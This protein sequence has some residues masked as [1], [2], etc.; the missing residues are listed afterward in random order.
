MS[1]RSLFFAGAATLAIS[2]ALLVLGAVVDSAAVM[3][4]GM[5][6]VVV[7]L[8][9][10]EWWSWREYGPR[11]RL[12]VGG[13]LLVVVTG[14]ALAS[15]LTG[16]ES[17]KSQRSGSPLGARTTLLGTNEPYSSDFPKQADLAPRIEKMLSIEL[18]DDFGCLVY[19]AR[20]QPLIANVTS[21]GAADAH[22]VI[23]A[24][25]LGGTV[26][27]KTPR[28]MFTD[29][30]RSELLRRLQRENPEPAAITFDETDGVGAACDRIVIELN[31]TAPP[32]VFERARVWIGARQRE[33]GS[34][35][36]VV[37]VGHA[38]LNDE[39]S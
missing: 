27:V 6:A 22:G 28:E 35:R 32:A 4:A 23:A 8:L 10:R 31:D 14:A 37:S 26:Q 1:D 2:V 25:E 17:S 34:D 39:N 5:V 38:E 21:D 20:T 13:L 3:A 11:G 36:V 9:L 30:E 24:E 12:L 16:G 7:V 18:G 15:A 29:R 33:L 19:P